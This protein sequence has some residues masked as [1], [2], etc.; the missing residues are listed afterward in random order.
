MNRRHARIVLLLTLAIAAA[1]ACATRARRAHVDRLAAADRLFARGC[2][3]CL[4]RAFEEYRALAA[5]GFRPPELTRRAFD[6]ALLVAAREK[7]LAL[8][9][10]GW[11]A[12]ARGLAPRTPRA[13][14]L[15]QLVDALPWAAGRH[16]PDFEHQGHTAAGPLLDA[17]DRWEAALGPLLSRGV[18]DTYLVAS[19]RCAFFPARRDEGLTPE[20]LAPVHAATPL[21]RYAVGT[22]R[23]S[24]SPALDAIDPDPD[25]HE[26]TFQRGRFQLFQ[27]GN[28][29][30]LEARALLEEAREVMPSMI[31]NTW[32][33]AGLLDTMGEYDRCADM[34]AEARSAGAAPRESR[35]NE[36]ICL[37]HAGRRDEAV[38]RATELID[39]EGPFRGEAYY[40]R[41]ANRYDQQRLPDARADV[42]LT[43]PLYQD[44]AVYA[45]SGFV[46]YEMNQRAYA[47]TEFGEAFTRNGAYCT[48]PFYQGLIDAEQERWEPAQERYRLSVLCYE[49]EVYRQTRSLENAEAMD[50]ADPTR[51]GR[52]R[53]F[54]ASLDA[55]RLQLARAA[56]NVAYSYARLGDAPAA[57]PFAEKAAA[58]HDDMRELATTLLTQLRKGG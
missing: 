14:A 47:Y 10:D 51:E 33:L 50:P 18:T 42:E 32:L 57:I 34:Y 53:Q 16:D 41:A 31:A 36:T 8:E 37:T 56:Y 43:K 26:L 17:L 55:S 48:A 30:R 29:V 52:I 38:T 6:T 24:L 2:Y 27:P 5:A 44:A 28:V 1:P 13:D 7:E 4:T 25:F 54:R 39:T 9:A 46:A 45:L 21:M 22:C 49:S 58:G 15:L 40:W 12:T 3:V 20:V 23:P 35:L 19:A 11:I